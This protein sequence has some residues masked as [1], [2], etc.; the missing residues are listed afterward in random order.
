[1]LV[2]FGYLMTFLRWY[3]LGAVGL[4]MMITCLGMELAIAVE[5]FFK[6]GGA[7]MAHKIPVDLTALI[8]GDFA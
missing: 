3:G 6:E 1:M 7:S 2:G 5:P 4:T 8:D